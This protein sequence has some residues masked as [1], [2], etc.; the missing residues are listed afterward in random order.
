[1]VWGVQGGVPL[2]G[3]QVSLEIVPGVVWPCWGF[4]EVWLLHSPCHFPPQVPESLRALW[5]LRGLLPSQL[6]GASRSGA[7]QRL[8]REHQAAWARPFLGQDT[9]AGTGNRGQA[10][11]KSAPPLPD[12]SVRCSH[13]PSFLPSSLSFQAGPRWSPVKRPSNL[14]HWSRGEGARTV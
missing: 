10:A 1:M 11:R 6:R 8:P 3:S 5:A 9:R 13:L 14:E 12:H 7:V 2:H 4:A